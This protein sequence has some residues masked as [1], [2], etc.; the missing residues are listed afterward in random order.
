MATTGLA[1][2]RDLPQSAKV[3]ICNGA[4]IPE[5]ELEFAADVRRVHFQNDDEREYRVRFWHPTNE[6]NTA[7]EVVL[8]SLETITISLKENDEFV[9]RII[10]PGIEK[11]TG[12]GGPIRN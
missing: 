11:F 2:T 6:E 9:Y 8:R 1:S 7:I 5:G 3:R 12:P 10:G 4:A